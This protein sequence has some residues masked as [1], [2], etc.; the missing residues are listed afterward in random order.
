MLRTILVLGALVGTTLAAQAN[1]I[2]SSTFSSC[3]DARS[4]NS[5]TTQNFGSTTITNGHNARTGSSWSQTDQRIGGTTFTTGRAANGNSWSSTTQSLGG[6]FS[7][8]SGVDSSGRSFN[9]TCGPFGC[10]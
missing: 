1:C 7:S 6:G 4:G 8:Q 3:N 9:R 10:N 2:V 5:Y